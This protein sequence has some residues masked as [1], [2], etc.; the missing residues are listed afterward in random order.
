MQRFDVKADKTAYPVVVGCGAWK[1]LRE[2]VSR[3]YTSTFILTERRI[4]S[5][6]AK[7]FSRDSGLES[8]RVVFIPSGE[9]SKSL[10]QAERVA[11][12][13]LKQ[14]ADR[15]SLLVLFGG[16]VVGDLGGFVA[17]TY[18]R[19]IDCVQV[20]TTVVGQVDSAVGG[21]TAVNV[22][23]MKNLVGTFYPPR[24]VLADPRVLGSL[25]RRT[26][27]SGLYEVAKHAILDGP[28]F[29]ETFERELDSLLPESAPKL[30][31]VIAQAVKVKVDVVN[32]D[33][34]ESSLRQVLNL[35]H[36]FGHALEEATGYKRFLH[37]EAVGWGLL[38]VALMA[39]RLGY[40]ASRTAEDE[41]AST[42]RA[43]MSF[44]I[45][46][47]D[48][49]THEAHKDCD[50]ILLYNKNTP[51]RA[52][53]G[54]NAQLNE[55]RGRSRHRAHPPQR[56]GG[57]SDADRIRR[58]IW[59]IGPLPTIRDVSAKAIVRL[60]PHD[61]KAVGGKIHWVIPER[62]G[63]VQIVTGISLTEAEIAWKELRALE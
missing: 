17:S 9:K 59:R 1:E 14:G 42:N 3:G 39:E 32:R 60:L 53:R 51:I 7:D 26:F 33:E 22:G 34:R 44:R 31:G 2:L 23:A 35:G 5:R 50:S 24:M 55:S 58:L 54:P 41:G 38:A 11:G 8:A 18:M 20:P 6:W 16:G 37:G 10:A 21:K 52:R 48:S 13:L 15:R 36:T 46:D 27:R 4:W 25:G 62:I 12:S 47:W 63:K 29:F 40:L 45:R 57:M 19:G 56:P 49:E 28:E 43:G 30:E 61:K